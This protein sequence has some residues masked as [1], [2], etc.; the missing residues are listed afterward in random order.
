M[1][2]S[3]FRSIS[4]VKNQKTLQIVKQ[5]HRYLATR[6]NESKPYVDATIN[7][8]EQKSTTTTTTSNKSIIGSDELTNL[9]DAEFKKNDVVPIFKRS[10]LH[11]EK[12]AIKDSTGEYSYRQILESARILAAQLSDHSSGKNIHIHA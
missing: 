8:S 7:L 2:V 11:A 9:F 10:L 4:Y 1:A 12:I 6:V 3:F 5:C